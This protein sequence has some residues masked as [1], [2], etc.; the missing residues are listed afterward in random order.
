MQ[1]KKYG[2]FLSQ[3]RL[4]IPELNKEEIRWITFLN[5]LKNKSPFI[6]HDGNP[7]NITNQEEIINILTNDDGSL[8]MN[9]I[10]QFLKLP[11]TPE[12]QNISLPNTTPNQQRMIIK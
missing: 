11:Q 2:N 5:K 9:D 3:M 8:N 10:Y 6:L 4:T 1:S 7:V 12:T